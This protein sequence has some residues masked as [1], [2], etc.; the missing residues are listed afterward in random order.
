MDK[1]DKLTRR[2]FG[3]LVSAATVP[4]LSAQQNPEQA[5]TSTQTP[6]RPALGNWNR[7]LAPET[8]PFEG[9][10]EFSREDLTIKAEPFPMTQVRLLPNSIYHD[11]QEWNRGYMGRLAVDRLLYTF[12]AN[13]GLPV[14]SAKPLGGWEQPD[15]RQRS[16]E[17]RG[18]FWAII[19]RPARNWPQRRHEAKAKADYIVAELAKCQRSWAANT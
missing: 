9:P 19:F 12:R 7:P 10:L 4:M 15:N 14:G 2:K 3:A 1:R 18:H 5:G 13:A 8:P 17:L 11:A 16:S 6:A